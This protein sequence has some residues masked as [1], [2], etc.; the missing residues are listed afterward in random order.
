MATTKTIRVKNI[1][2]EWFDG[3]IGE[4]I[5]QIGDKL[6]RKFKKSKLSV[7][8][9]LFEEARNTVQALI[10]DKKRKLLLGKLPE[11]IGKPRELWKIIRKLSLREKKA[12]TTS[13]HNGNYKNY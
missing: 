6:L 12:P 5:R 7:D 8:E 3:E 2:N 4:K 10:K 1:T 13:K 9:I 11:N